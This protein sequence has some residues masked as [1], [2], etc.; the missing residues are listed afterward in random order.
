MIYQGTS[1]NTTGSGTEIGTS[2]FNSSDD[3]SYYVGL[4]YKE[5]EQHGYGTNSTIMTSLVNWYN[6]NLVG[7]ENDYIDTGTGFCSDRNLQSGSWDN[8]HDYASSGRMANNL[9]SLQC[10]EMDILTQDNGKLSNPIGLITT[11]E[12]MLGGIPVNGN[13]SN[14][15]LYTGRDYWTMSPNNFDNSYGTAY[16]RVINQYGLYQAYVGGKWGVRPVI[17]L[18]ADVQLTGSGTTSDPF[19][20][21]GAS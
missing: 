12:A 7:Y 21:V 14:S 5:N 8:W 2:A 6:N 15:Y 9:P 11:D 16:N 4:V 13:G 19:K 1:V 10:N 18:R 17:N 3:K 20:V